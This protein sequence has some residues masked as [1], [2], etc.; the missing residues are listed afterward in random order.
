MGMTTG[1]R[2]GEQVSAASARKFGF[3]P[4]ATER[5]PGVVAFDV[6]L[7]GAMTPRTIKS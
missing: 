3:A 1:I 7:G 4:F 2:P 6:P 5:A